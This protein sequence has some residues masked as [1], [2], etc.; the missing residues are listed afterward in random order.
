MRSPVRVWFRRCAAAARPGFGRAHN[1][2][3]RRSDRLQAFCALG[4]VLL[5]LAVLPVALVGSLR[6]WQH[7]SQVSAQERSE[8][9][10]VPATVVE[11]DPETQLARSHLATLSWVYPDRVEHTGHITVTSATVAGDSVPVWVDDRGAMTPAPTS[12][13]NVWLDTL[14]FGLGLTGAAV[15][16]GVFWYRGSRFWLDR[17]RTKALDSE[18]R[19]LNGSRSEG[20]H[21]G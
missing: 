5:V 20:F 13:L 4:A 11:A 21:R 15:L 19:E 17:R 6:T 2:L 10:L 12:T 3:R 14:G 8:R 7:Y 18:W 1:P 9:H 16:V